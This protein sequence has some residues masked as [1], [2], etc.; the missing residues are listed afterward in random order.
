MALLHR[1]ELRPS[2]IELVTGWAPDQPWFEAGAGAEP[3]TVAAFRFDDPAGE[4]GIETLLV[5]AGDGPVLQIPLTYRAAPLDGADAWLIGTM[6][7]SVLGKRWVYDGAGDPAYLTAVATAALTGGHQADLF[8]DVDGELVRRE[9]TALVT[10]SG[11]SSTPVP[12]LA[13]VGEVSVRDEPGATVVQVGDLRLV[14]L[15]TLAARDSTDGPERD[16]ASA[17]LTGTWSDQ[18]EPRQLVVVLASLH[19]P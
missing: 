16:A 13:S 11:E 14:I 19:R 10:G 7:H 8:V 6:Q 17:V 3:T 18:V 15:R 1:A 12:P 5:R 9:P 4:V 2:K